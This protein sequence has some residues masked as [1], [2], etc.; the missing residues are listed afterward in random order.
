MG[1]TTILQVSED[2]GVN[3][4]CYVRVS[5][6]QQN[7]DRQLIST[8]A[9]AT[10]RLGADPNDV[11]VYRDKRTG[12]NVSRSGYQRLMRDVEDGAVDVVVAHEVSRIA[13]SIADLERTAE[14][15]RDAGVELHIVSESLVVRPDEDDPYQRALFQMLG[16]FA[17]LEAEIKRQNIR[18]GI[19]ARKESDDYKH[20]PA[21]LGFTKD[22]GALVESEDYHRVCEVL[23]Q[24]VR[25]DMSQRQ[26]SKELDTSRRTVRRA[27]EKRAD[28]YGL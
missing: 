23:E 19:A 25:G 15:L 18:E 27:V 1:V 14:R 21:P 2:M 20:G 26:A 16:V 5:T 17:E 9:Y 12:T 24:V 4:A 10:D 13:R 3:V 28:L 6:A 11:E 8:Q 22:S 7:L